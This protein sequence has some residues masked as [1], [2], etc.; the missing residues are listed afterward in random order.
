MQDTNKP[1]FDGVAYY[2]PPSLSAQR[3]T[4]ISTIL[5]QNGAISESLE[6]ATHIITNTHYFE[7]WRDIDEHASIVSEEWVDRSII[8]GKLQPPQYYSADPAMIFSGVVACATGLTAS[9]LEVLSAGV[10]ALGGQWRTGL[11][12]D[13]THL[14]ALS[15]GSYKYETAMHFRKLTGLK[16]VLPHWFDDAV[17]LGIRSLPTT[18]YE[19]PNPKMLQPFPDDGAPEG[20]TSLKKS[21]TPTGDKR[22]LYHTA[23]ISP[24]AGE[25]RAEKRNVWQ[26]RKIMLSTTLELAGGR[27][28]AVE[29]G[30]L[31]AGGDIVEFE[32]N[33]GDGDA[34]EEAQRVEEADVFVT[35]YRHGKAYIK[36]VKAKKTIGTLTWLFHVESTG[37]IS[38][39]TDQLLHYPIPKRPIENFSHHEITV[40]NYTGDAREY[41]KKLI[42]AM[43][44][45]FTASMSAK[46]TVVIAAFIHGNKTERARSWSI[47]IVNHTWLE[48]CFVQWRSLTVGLEK[49]ILFPPRFDF[50]QVLAERGVGKM[51]LDDA[52]LDIG[53]DEDEDDEPEAKKAHPLEPVGTGI[54]ATDAM[55]VEHDLFGP[56]NGDAMDVDDET[57]TRSRTRTVSPK[58][59]PA[60]SAKK[61]PKKRPTKPQSEGSDDDNLP[62]KPVRRL[63]RRSGTK[64]ELFPPT[65]SPAKQT[66]AARRA[67]EAEEAAS[68]RQGKQVLSDLSDMESEIETRKSTKAKA[69]PRASNKTDDDTDAGSRHDDKG[70]AP[71][72]T[73]GKPSRTPQRMDSVLIP[74][75]PKSPTK[76]PRR[77]ESL[78]ITA[79]EASAPSPPKRSRPV[80]STKASSADSHSQP[81][82]DTSGPMPPKK[83]RAAHNN[84]VESSVDS[85]Q[86]VAGPSGLTRTPSRRSAATKATQKLHDEIM[87]DVLNYQHDM[88]K[89]GRARDRAFDRSVDMTD[90]SAPAKKRRQSGHAEELAAVSDDE[91]RDKKK[92]RR[93]GSRESGKGVDKALANGKGK[94]KSKTS[95]RNT[96]DAESEAE[97]SVP[98]RSKSRSAKQRVVDGDVDTA[99]SSSNSHGIKVMTTGVSL[100][101][102]VVKNL[103][104]IGINMT[105]KPSE[106]T[107]VVTKHLGRTE[108][109]L[110]A[111]AVSPFVLT[112]AWANATAAAKRVMPEDE[113]ALQDPESEKKFNLKLSDALERG[114]LVGG[115]LL[116]QKTFYVT[117][118]VKI[119]TKLLR[120][121]IAANGG[122]LVTQS[123]TLRILKGNVNRH[124]ISCPEDASIWRPL[125]EA[126]FV[127]Y[128]PE[129]I[130]TGALKQE[131]EWKNPKHILSG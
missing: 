31:R 114:K 5:N 97:G 15:A 59:A 11:T 102:D 126:G 2:L 122:T 123:P 20:V 86:P 82:D 9:D 73:N 13:V 12:K 72:T 79:Y 14:F 66:R 120:N 121:V 33:G 131:M 115:R 38:S 7:G 84:R 83:G 65:P 113:Y 57:T 128:N 55:E 16:V 30:I 87:P 29:A 21:K 129:L 77:T 104:K 92:K 52:E 100:T 37:I 35:R 89:S 10:V 85:A 117:P 130:L 36:A 78:R 64:F 69:K 68:A 118:K 1:I 105:T 51:V 45:T 42:I 119:E 81:A 32:S 116:S 71:A 107:H 26:G 62:T 27:R 75:L 76:T 50:A 99:S 110:C 108:K 28:E 93:V 103:R 106:C 25:A 18:E 91:G 101:D 22:T 111:M 60:S 74:P 61:T 88:K 80:P 40:T 48:D 95:R 125:A 94:A 8:L 6:H 53:G 96:S 90:H 67:Q 98:A 34:R 46:N 43:G 70:K 19:W 41:L 17:R 124:V 4:E 44:A 54:S 39:P 109:L 49:Y 63:T 3:Q 112:E 24:D 56:D 47:P 58:K 23:Q 127:I